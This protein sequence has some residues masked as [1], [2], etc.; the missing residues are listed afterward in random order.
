MS[1]SSATVRRQAAVVDQF[2]DHPKPHGSAQAI[3]AGSVFL[4]TSCAALYFLLEPYS[5]LSLVTTVL[6]W[7]L[8]AYL[9]WRSLEHHQHSVFGQANA[10]TLIRAVSTT[11]LAGF[12]PIAADITSPG[13]LWAIAIAA[14]ITLC[15]DGLDG[16]L[17]R[18]KG[19]S[20]E[21]GARF[22]METDAL[23]AL[24]ITLFLWQSD[25]LG[26]WVIGLGLMRYA[27]L[28]AAIWLVPLQA[29]LYP[30]LRRKA[31]CVV[32]VGALCLMLFPPLSSL[33]AAMVG[34]LALISLTYSFGV[35][36]A[37]LFRQHGTSQTYTEQQNQ[38]R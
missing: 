23:L 4:S 17:A 30:S 21:F 8:I 26:V 7:T 1:G 6:T 24:I 25:K 27:F 28:T 15:M 37:W 3:T 19:L 10:V 33:Q 35:D 2:A 29:E 13:I 32:Q 31:I 36:I 38:T 12:V 20:S 11:I 14:T 22:D 5:L 16:Y 18:K 9:V 34:L